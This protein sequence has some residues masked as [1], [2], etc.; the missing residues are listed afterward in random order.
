MRFNSHYSSSKSNL[1]TVES[2][3]GERLLIE[4]GCTPKQLQKAIDYQLN[5][6]IGCL[7]THEHRDH[8]KS[9]EWLLDNGIDVYMSKGTM[10]ALGLIHRRI[11]IIEDKHPVMVSPY[12]VFPFNVEHDAAEPLGFIVKED[13]E[14]LFFVTD[15]SH[16][17]QRFGCQFSV[18]A[19]CCNYDGKWLKDQV[20]AGKI[21]ETY[22]KR[23]LT[24]HMEKK[25]T[26]S[27][28]K[29]CCNLDKCTEIHL[30]HMSGTNIDKEK[31]RA[32]IENELFI[33]TLIAGK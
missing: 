21:N 12:E 13:A 25:V 31:I 16:I 23:L 33:K 3:G 6:I 14:A 2:A 7:L 9:A 24:S 15:T 10:Q 11:H 32:E 17:K 5:N 19:I 22:A 8:S 29:D 1:Y 4:C 20:E 26:K 18:I 27:Y 28:I 30:L